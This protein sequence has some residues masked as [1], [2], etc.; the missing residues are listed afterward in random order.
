[1]DW[2][3]EHGMES[4]RMEGNESGTERER[5]AGDST[6]LQDLTATEQ[7][8]VCSVGASA[9]FL[10]LLVV[11]QLV[12]TS[13]PVEKLQQRRP[14]TVLYRLMNGAIKRAKHL[15]LRRTIPSNR[16]QPFF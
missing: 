6:R 5:R 14:Q 3:R 1:M 11:V 8:E 15:P 16:S 12:R 7:S 4:N 10:G 2:N 9:C 13:L